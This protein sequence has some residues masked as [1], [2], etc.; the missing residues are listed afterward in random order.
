MLREE[1]SGIAVVGHA[2]FAVKHFRFVGDEPS[3]IYDWDS[4]AGDLEPVIVGEAARGFTMTWH[5]PGVSAVPTIDEVAA[6][7]TAYER[8][9]GIP[10]STEE[11]RTAR[12]AATLATAYT[13]RCEASIDE[14]RAP[15]DS[16]RALLAEVDSSQLLPV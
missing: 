10:F 12:A 5:L 15:P 8:A 16:F 14:R 13:A 4:L 1:Q 7:L 9:R 2:D 6:F 11:R 3:V